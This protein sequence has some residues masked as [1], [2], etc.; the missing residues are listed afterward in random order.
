MRVQSYRVVL[1]GSAG[2]RY[3]SGGNFTVAVAV[4]PL[5]LVEKNCDG[6]T[7]TFLPNF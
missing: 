3:C 1:S 7:V 5:H 4:V 6:I 2:Y